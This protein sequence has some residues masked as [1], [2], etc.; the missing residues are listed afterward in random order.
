MYAAKGKCGHDACH[1]KYCSLT[2]EQRDSPGQGD[3]LQSFVAL[4]NVPAVNAVILECQSCAV[5]HS[6]DFTKIGLK[7]ASPVCSISTLPVY[8]YV[9]IKVLL[10][11]VYIHISVKT[12]YTNLFM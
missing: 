11:S 9:N 4:K 5:L 3:R 10:A 12:K 8:L 7:D 6:L 1:S 2:A